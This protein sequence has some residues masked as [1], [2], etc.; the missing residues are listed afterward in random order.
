MFLGDFIEVK[1]MVTTAYW[2]VDMK[3]NAF[4]LLRDEQGR[5][6]QIRFVHPMETP[7]QLGNI[8][9]QGYLS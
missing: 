1:S 9:E 5:I 2:N 8:H 4:A 3:N 6:A 7:L